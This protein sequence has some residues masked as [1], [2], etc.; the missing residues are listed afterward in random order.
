VIGNWLCVC[1]IQQVPTRVIHVKPK[2]ADSMRQLLQGVCGAYG[3]RLSERPG[4]LL[5]WS[6]VT[7]T[8]T[9][10]NLDPV[11]TALERWNRER[12]KR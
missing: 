4:R 7:F 5:W 2:D 9:G 6:W 8:V 10:D 12:N 1:Y 3:A 11:K